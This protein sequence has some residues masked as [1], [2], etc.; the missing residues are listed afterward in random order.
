[1]RR[2]EPWVRW[3][4][5]AAIVLSAGPGFAEQ[6]LSVEEAQARL[7]P[8]ETLVPSPVVLT[9]DEVKAIQKAAHVR[10]RSKEVQLWR[11]PGGGLFFVDAVLGKHENITWALALNADG[12]VKDLE[13][14]E[15]R[16][17]Y[18]YQVREAKWRAQFREK[19]HGAPLELDRDIK[20]I[21]GATLSCLH[22][23][24]GVRRLLATYE[25]V[26]AK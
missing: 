7:F 26:L 16:E 22:I 14:L 15:Y 13:I 9:P 8:G 4:A 21:S 3:L 19:K 10:V 24:D 11:A 5:P 18:G 2:P 23:T 17:T 1:M 25:L 12:S 20:N 6:Y